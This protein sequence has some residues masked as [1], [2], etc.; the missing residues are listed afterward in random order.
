MDA[1]EERLQVEAARRD[2]AKFGDLY[3]RHFDRVYAF[4]VCRVRDRAAAE[5]VTAEVFQ[6]ALAAL[7]TFELRGA[8]FGAWLIRIAA[9]AITDRA[10]RKTREQPVPSGAAEPAVDPEAEAFEQRVDLFRFVDDL[11]ADQRRVIIE[12]FVEERSIREIA[13]RMNRTEG[14]VKQL[15]LRALQNLRARMENADA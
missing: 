7:P 4:V 14:A 12:R 1:D 10:R 2:P 8:P 6:K 5:D 11:P 9:N 3:D 13:G 15:Q